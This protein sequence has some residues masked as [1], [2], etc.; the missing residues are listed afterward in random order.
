MRTV[1]VGN[2]LR[3]LASEIAVDHIVPFLRQDLPP[4][5]LRVGVIGG[6]EAAAHAI[7]EFVELGTLN[8][9]NDYILVKLDMKNAFSTVRR[10]NILEIC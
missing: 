10:E 6:C 9:I 1:A 7:R 2:V 5:Q 8:K 3:R 4:V